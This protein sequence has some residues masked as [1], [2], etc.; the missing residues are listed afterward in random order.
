MVPISS[1]HLHQILDQRNPIRTKRP[2]F[3]GLFGVYEKKSCP[4]TPIDIWGQIW[5]QCHKAT[6]SCPQMP[7]TD[8]AIQNAKPDNKPRRMYDS[9]GL[10]L[11][12]APSGGKWWRLKYRFEGKETHCHVKRPANVTMPAKVLD[13]PETR[14]SIQGAGRCIRS[15]S[16]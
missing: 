12:I 15:A 14:R 9:G 10:Y 4:M 7:L 3:S 2:L 11:E 5:G 6:Q 13:R 16:P 1:H 8:K